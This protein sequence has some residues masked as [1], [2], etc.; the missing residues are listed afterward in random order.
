MNAKNSNF[1]WSCG[2]RGREHVTMLHRVSWISW[3]SITSSHPRPHQRPIL[4]HAHSWEQRTLGTKQE[5]KP[6]GLLLQILC[7]QL[8]AFILT[9]S[10][11]IIQWLH[12]FSLGCG[13]QQQKEPYCC[14]FVSMQQLSGGKRNIK[15]QLIYWS[16]KGKRSRPGL[17]WDCCY[18]WHD[19]KM[20]K[21]WERWLLVWLLLISADGWV[22]GGERDKQRQFMISII[23]VTSAQQHNAWG[24]EWSGAGAQDALFNKTTTCSLCNYT[25]PIFAWKFF[26]SQAFT[27][28]QRSLNLIDGISVAPTL[29]AI[30]YA[31]KLQADRFSTGLLGF[32]VKKGL[33]LL[34]LHL[35]V[36]HN[37]S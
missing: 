3:I 21:T 14:W 5:V 4:W 7:Y 12:P 28:R 19:L 22:T 11:W 25:F 35:S 34:L 20:Q 26:F 31:F 18:L 37:S 2:S 32:I 24:L 36:T 33:L 10:A 30:K 9:Y 8:E 1:A 23:N 15:N 6:N 13:P 29:K 17:Q 27:T 16:A